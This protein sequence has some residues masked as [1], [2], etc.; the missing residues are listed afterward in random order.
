MVDG[1]TTRLEKVIGLAEDILHKSHS[2]LIVCNTKTEASYLFNEASRLAVQ[3]FH[4]SAGMCGAHRRATLN[5]LTRALN[6]TVGNI[7]V[8]CISTQVIEA[9][10][11]ISF[12]NVIRISAG[13]DSIVQAA[14]RCNRN[15]EFDAKKNV[16]IIRLA[17]ERLGPLKEIA[18]AQD[19]SN[20]LLEEYRITP[21]QFN[22]DL[23]SDAAVRYYYRRLYS[24]MASDTMDYPTDGEPTLFSMLSENNVYKSRSRDAGKYFMEQAFKTAGDLFKV[25]DEETQTIIVPY[26]EGANIISTLDSPTAESDLEYIRAIIAKA[27]DY[28]VNLYQEP[29]DRLQKLGAIRSICNGNV[30]ALDTEYYSN[31]TGVLSEKEI[32]EGRPNCVTQIQ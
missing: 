12:E 16:Y 32:K 22:Y 9:G 18:R 11:D 23:A 3:R 2:L 8:L 13:L 7:P 6:N 19:A 24:R 1:G 17:D 10:I 31:S 25:F 30:Y 20:D 15:G 14:G 26:S 28:C 29:F 27:G 5:E 4:L 21:A